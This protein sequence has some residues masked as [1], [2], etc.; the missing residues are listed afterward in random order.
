MSSW[1]DGWLVHFN[2]KHIPEVNVYPNVSVFNRK[3]YTFGEKGEV[4][5]KFD[6]IDDT[7]ASYDEVAY[8]DTK[9]C[10]FRVSQDD[11]IITVHV[12]DDYVVVGKLSDRYVQTN[13]LSKYDVVIR[14][15]KDY[16]V[17]PLATLYDPKEL[18]LDDFAECAKSRLGS[19]F[20]SYINDIR[21]PSQ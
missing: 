17:V 14:D 7:I 20:E 21:D 5:I 11:Y 1:E 2:K 18:K 12:G 16:N 6:Y 15:I 8:L 9:S 4:F 10:I 3:I 19:R 13:G